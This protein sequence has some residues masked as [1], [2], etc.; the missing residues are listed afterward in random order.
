MVWYTTNDW[1]IHSCRPP[2]NWGKGEEN[3]T[4]GKRGKK[5]ERKARKARRKK[6]KKAEENAWS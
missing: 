3:Q 6:G 2:D 5:K 4:K 1:P